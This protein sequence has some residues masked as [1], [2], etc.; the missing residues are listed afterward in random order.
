M[1]KAIRCMTRILLIPACLILTNC[2]S[3]PKDPGEML[4]I[5]LLESSSKPEKA[6]AAYEKSGQEGRTALIRVF[7]MI[8]PEGEVYYQQ[9]R[10]F[11]NGRNFDA[12]VE[13]LSEDPDFLRAI[14]KVSDTWPRDP[15]PY[16]RPGR[17]GGIP[18]IEAPKPAGK[19]PNE[20]EWVL[21]RDEGIHTSWAAS[22]PVT[23]PRLGAAWEMYIKRHPGK[24]IDAFLAMLAHLPAETTLADGRRLRQAVELCA[25]LAET[26][27]PAQQRFIFTNRLDSRFL[28]AWKPTPETWLLAY[29]EDL[30][31]ALWRDEGKDSQ[32]SFD[33]PWEKL[34]DE[35]ITPESGKAL[36]FFNQAGA[37]PR[38]SPRLMREILQRENA[39]ASLC[40]YAR[41]INVTLSRTTLF[42]YFPE[43]ATHYS[44]HSMFSAVRSDLTVTCREAQS[45]KEFWTKTFLGGEPPKET[46]APS[47]G[48]SYVSGSLPW[49]ETYAAI[50][51]CVAQ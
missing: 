8:K 2:D 16:R 9:N 25:P 14:L 10:N 37:E 20:L 3:G 28:Y 1:R 44:Q 30:G 11:I 51:E 12:F 36:V 27:T 13:K 19:R 43:G 39:A 7:F 21:D 41:Q 32:L 48:V 42:T 29:P 38:L 40:H 22:L 33:I 31:F 35:A 49:E 23:D 18:A 46:Y 26:L 24:G 6:M 15:V 34:R 4:S 45:G 47:G 50:R 17:Q 5:V